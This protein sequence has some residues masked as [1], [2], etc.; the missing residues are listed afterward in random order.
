MPTFTPAYLEQIGTQV[1][2]AIS[3]PADEASLV[4]KELVYANLL[5]MDSHGIIRVP[6]YVNTIAD[7]EIVPGAKTTLS[8][9]TATTAIVDGGH[10][11]GQVVAFRAL[12]IALEK[13][14]THNISCVLAHNCN[15]VGRL[16][17]Y[18]Q[19]AAEQDMICLATTTW[20]MYGHHVAPFG[21]REGRL[22]TNPIAYGIPT[23]DHPVLA[24]FAT[25]VM[26]EGKV[27]VSLHQ[28]NPLP[29]N[30]IVD[31]A[32]KP[33]ND[34][35]DFYGPPKGAM[36]TF[37]G[38]VGYKGYALSLLVEILG[39]TLAGIQVDDPERLGNGLCL[40]VINPAA[41]GDL[42]NF[43]ALM[44]DVSTYMKSAELADGFQ[45]IL[46][47]GELDFRN[48]ARRQQEG[49]PLADTTWTQIQKAAHSVGVEVKIESE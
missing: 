34:P 27:R 20:P 22:S 38:L 47:P 25:S 40:I 48:V 9:E 32:G 36:L 19:R 29:D 14:R 3:V 43:K 39:A 4:A 28:G 1:F 15:H 12:D 23:D 30:A 42:I 17:A 16:G 5:G 35:A 45:E 6:Q 2:E 37:G 7:G 11:F 26:S 8:K 33:T 44:A 10:N 24:D 41:F 18:P 21:G 46:M 31:S 49:I 13:A